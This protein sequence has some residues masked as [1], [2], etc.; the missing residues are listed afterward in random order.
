MTTPAALKALLD[1]DEKNFMVASTPGGIEAQEARGQQELVNNEALPECSN[2]DRADLE[3][4]GFIFKGLIDN[5]F[6][7]VQLPEGWKKVATDHS[8]HSNLLDERGRKRGSIFYKAAFYDRRADWFLE[9]RF[10]RSVQPV[11]GYDQDYDNE[12]TQRE[13][14][15]T[16]CDEVIWQSGAVGPSGN[17][18]CYD[19]D[20]VLS[21]LGTEWLE[22]NYPDWKDPLAYWE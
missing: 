1:G 22:E 3:T 17:L 15:V 7:E 13:C 4:L 12:T 11:G 20:N 10:S 16:D 6:V 9:R 18:K 5:L 8:M 2:C 19:I 21:P 14:I